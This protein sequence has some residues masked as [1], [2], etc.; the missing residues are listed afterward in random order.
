MNKSEEVLKMFED[1]LN[2]TVCVWDFSFD[3]GE[4]L[5]YEDGDKLF[6]ENEPL[7]DLLND[8]LP[9]MLEELNSYELS[10][11]R[12]WL[13]EYHDKIKKMI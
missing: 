7:F 6:E 2:G 10:D 5:A 1:V 12:D 13:E 3:F 9:M 4:W 11:N 8:N